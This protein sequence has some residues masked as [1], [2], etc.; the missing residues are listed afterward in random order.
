[1]LT[2][3]KR[4]LA[5]VQSDYGFYIN[6]QTNPAAAL[7]GYDLSPD[8]RSALIDPEKLADVFKRGIVN[9]LVITISGTHDWLNQAVPAN[10][11]DTD[12]DAR[13]VVEVDAIQRASTG[14]ERT[15]AVVRL[16]ELIG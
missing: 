9:K 3:F 4:A 8:E 5:R 1:M 13:V 16:M 2:G 11:E 12:H 7:V 6:C 15:D 14:K 10:A